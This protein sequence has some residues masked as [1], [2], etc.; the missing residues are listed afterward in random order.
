MTPDDIYRAYDDLRPSDEAKERMLQA[1]RA[2]AATAPRRL[3]PSKRRPFRGALILAAALVLVLV[4]ATVTYATDLFGLR[5]AILYHKNGD[6]GEPYD[7]TDVLSLQGLA[8]SP[9]A[10]A[11]MRWQNFY[12]SYDPDGMI[13]A[14]IG[15]GDTGLDAR[16]DAYP[17]Y[18]QEMA[19]ELDAIAN[20]YGLQL[21]NR[22]TL[23]GI[24]DALPERIANVLPKSCGAYG[25]VFD[26]G[27]AYDSGSFMAEGTFTF[28]DGRWPYPVGYQFVCS[29]KGYLSVSYLPI[30][31]AEDYAQWAYETA[32]GAVVTLAMG[33]DKA[34]I[35]A[36]LPDAYLVVNVLD[37]RWGDTEAGEV[38]MPQEVLEAI[39]DAFAFDQI[40]EGK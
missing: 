18:T 17:C 19:D 40:G 39:A 4:F 5:S 8:D 2:E 11:N 22:P 26:G 24:G 20:E 38:T 34:L 30:G 14:S 33:P 10:M 36:N 12:N 37:V 32:S 27:Y 29:E 25:H 28:S 1:I 35:I 7:N 15:N 9:E 6:T 16:Y 3:A 21:L 31:N 13:L 23:Y